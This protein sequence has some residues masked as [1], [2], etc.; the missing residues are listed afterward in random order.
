[1]F[2][3]TVGG[4]RLMRSGRGPWLRLMLLAVCFLAG[5]FLGQVLSARVSADTAGELTEYLNGYFSLNFP[6]EPSAKTVASALVVYFRYP[7]LAFL[8]GFASVG[9]ALLPAVTAAYGFFLSF[10]VCCFTAAFGRNGVLLALAV[11]GLRCLITLPCYFSV[12]VP[13]LEK[14][15]ALAAL[16]L[17][18]SGRPA[19]PVYGRSWWLRFGAVGA[20]LLFGVLTELL[21]S[22]RLL[23]WV[24]GLIFR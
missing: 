17:K 10:S 5:L 19:P 24:L 20:V 6:P 15:V 7:L 23:N 13:A 21:V 11:F 16:S 14:S 18:K 8:L 2:V 1:M 12:A 9:A 3:G 4:R 22:P